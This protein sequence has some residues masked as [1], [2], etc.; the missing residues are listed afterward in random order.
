MKNKM[1]VHVLIEIEDQ[2]EK[3]KETGVLSYTSLSKLMHDDT[4]G[5]DVL[6]KAIDLAKAMPKR[7]IEVAIQEYDASSPKIDELKLVRDLADKYG[8]ERGDVV[9]RIQYVRRINKETKGG[10]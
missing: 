1:P 9:L 8:V 10:N 2:L 3:E 6:A 7:E 5:C 4:V